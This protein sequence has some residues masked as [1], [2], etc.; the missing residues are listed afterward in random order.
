MVINYEHVTLLM[1]DISDDAELRGRIR[2]NVAMLAEGA[3]ARINSLLIELD[4]RRKQVGIR[5]ALGEILNMTEELREHQHSSQERSKEAVSSVM[6][7][8][9]S[10]FV[11]LGLTSAQESELIGLLENLRQEVACVGLSAQEVDHKLQRVTRSLQSI[12]EERL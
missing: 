3:E 8:F 2:D 11:R 12:A 6:L 7:C 9:E 5:Y 10:A 1:S 4:N